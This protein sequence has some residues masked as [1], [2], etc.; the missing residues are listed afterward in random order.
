M[1]HFT[2][3][4]MIEDYPR[5]YAHA[6]LLELYL[7]DTQTGCKPDVTEW[8]RDAKHGVSVRIQLY[9]TPNVWLLDDA[10]KMYGESGATEHTLAIRCALERLVITRNRIARESVDSVAVG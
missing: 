6:D 5:L 4:R 2:H 7:Y 3:K 10:V 8:A 9:C 1:P